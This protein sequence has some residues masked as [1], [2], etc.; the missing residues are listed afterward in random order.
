[1]ALPILA[2]SVS[3]VFGLALGGPANVQSVEVAE[4]CEVHGI[5]ASFAAP[6]PEGNAVLS[7]VDRTEMIDG[8]P[9]PWSSLTIYSCDTGRAIRVDWENAD[10]AMR[11]RA[12]LRNSRTEFTKWSEIMTAK[13]KDDNRPVPKVN[14]PWIDNGQGACA[15]RLHYGIEVTQ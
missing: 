15:C 4:N 14:A 9:H 5:D 11:L 10:Q 8:T 7:A 3:N 12:K 6:V 2:I 13:A 1:M